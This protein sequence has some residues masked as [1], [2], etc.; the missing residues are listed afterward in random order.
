MKFSEM[1]EQTWSELQTYFDTCLIPY[2]GLTGRETPWEVTASL[3]RLRDFMD[4]VE[5]PFKGRVITYPALQY[6]GPS[7]TQFLNDICQKVK[8]IGF[9]YAVVITADHELEIK[10]IPESALVLS[11][12]RLMADDDLQISTAVTTLIREMWE[13]EDKL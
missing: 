2:T 13:K 11:R 6:G 1:D 12:P 10:D 5:I 9:I 7:V 8:S 3:E 4:L